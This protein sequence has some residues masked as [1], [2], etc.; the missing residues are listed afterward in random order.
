[1]MNAHSSVRYNL[2]KEL[3]NY[4]LYHLKKELEK[5]EELLNQ[6]TFIGISYKDSI[7]NTINLLQNE[8]KDLKIS[9][10]P[11]INL[12]KE[13]WKLNITRGR[14]RFLGDPK[15]FEKKI[16]YAENQIFL[17]R[18]L[19]I[20]TKSSSLR[21]QFIREMMRNIQLLRVNGKPIN[22]EMIYLGESNM[23]PLL[24]R[25]VRWEDI[26]PNISRKILY[27]QNA[28]IQTVA[29]RVID[30]EIHNSLRK[31]DEILKA[32]LPEQI[33]EEVKR[34]GKVAPKIFSNVS[35]LF[36]DLV[37]FTEIS[38]RLTPDQLLEELDD[39]FSHLDKI[40]AM[41]H[42]EKIK[43][44]GDSYMAVGGFD[45]EFLHPVNSI[46]CALR[47]Q[48]FMRKYYLSQNRKNLPAWKIRIGINS[49][50]VVAGVLG[51]KRFN[52]DI[53]GDTVNIAQRMESNSE[54]GKIN[55]SKIT[56]EQ[57]KDFFTFENR[58]LLNVKGKGELEMYYI[59]GIKP[60][61]SLNGLGRTP[62]KAFRKKYEQ[63]LQKN[64]DK[65]DILW[66]ENEIS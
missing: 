31:T 4:F 33:A 37:G 62:N 39:C 55:V 23:F 20:K 10:H 51:E 66:T 32:I 38:S 22:F 11:R 63:L 7:D 60:D 64:I 42:L 53:W 24:E 41:H 30:Q 48:E 3:T 16:F 14:G 26:A 50:P 28:F 44:I 65:K 43:T 18:I 5:P 49:G 52:Y 61:L 1:M 45:E 17:F 9:K 13:W 58:G 25:I 34:K 6:K 29:Y 56:Y 21:R 19:D 36:C 12:F 54:A 40:C 57:A 59:V 47:I 15:P 8:F 46:L 27:E 2:S 35:V